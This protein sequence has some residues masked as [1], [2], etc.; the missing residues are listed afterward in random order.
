MIEGLFFRKFFFVI[1]DMYFLVVAHSRVVPSI[2]L[3]TFRKMDFRD[4]L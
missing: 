2:E 4:T 3:H 1:A